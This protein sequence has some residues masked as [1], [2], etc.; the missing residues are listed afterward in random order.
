M[1]KIKQITKLNQKHKGK[2]IKRQGL[3]KEKNDYGKEYYKKNREKILK[4]MIEYRKNNPGKI[5]EQRR[6]KY[7]RNRKKELNYNKEYRKNNPEKIR[8]KLNNYYSK[9]KDK[10]RNYQKV[11]K[12]KNYEKVR[13]REKIYRNKNRDKLRIRIKTIRKFP[14]KENQL[15]EVCKINKATE[16]HHEDYNKPDDIIFL[17]STCHG[18]IHR[19]DSR[20]GLNVSVNELRELADDLASET[21]KFNLELGVEDIIDFDKK[22]LVGIVNKTGS[23]DAWKIENEKERGFKNGI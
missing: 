9:N 21:R 14:I 17:C 12:N 10:L 1:I 5:K 7:L 22:W 11:Y 18:I 4:R 19:K 6:Q 20:Q 15:C 2:F 16:R 13:E 23:S 8:K 3:K